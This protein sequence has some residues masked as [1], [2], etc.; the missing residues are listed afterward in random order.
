VLLL[1]PPV[2]VSEI[3]TTL[4]TVLTIV[5]TDKAKRFDHSSCHRKVSGRSRRAGIGRRL[6][7]S[8]VAPAEVQRLFTAHF[9]NMYPQTASAMVQDASN[10]I[11]V[12]ML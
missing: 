7:G 2:A 8:G 10:W 5:N 9:I 12:N 11:I 1:G 6:E 3:S 4:D